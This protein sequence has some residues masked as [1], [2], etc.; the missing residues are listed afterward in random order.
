MSMPASGCLGICTCPGGACSS[1]STAVGTGSGSLCA[2]SV[3]AGKSAPHAMSEFYGYEPPSKCI[4]LTET[5]SDYTAYCWVKCASVNS[6][7]A[8]GSEECYCLSLCSYLCACSAGVQNWASI[9]VKCGGNGVLYCCVNST[10]EFNTQTVNLTIYQGDTVCI[11]IAA[12]A[13]SDGPYDALASVTISGVTGI[14]GNF[15]IGT[16]CYTI[17]LCVPV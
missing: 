5:Y 9:C 4:D 14:V 2:L 15:S 8:M 10:E 13:D 12:C 1:I 3:S 7:P 6:S 16:T 11:C 17:D